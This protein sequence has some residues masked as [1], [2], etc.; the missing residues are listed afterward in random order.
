[1]S[2]QKALQNFRTW[3]TLLQSQKLFE[4]DGMII[5]KQGRVVYMVALSVIFAIMPF[6]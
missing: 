5:H 1:M 2:H 6:L 4:S 3:S